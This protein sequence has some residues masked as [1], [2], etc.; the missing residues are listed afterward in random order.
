MWTGCAREGVHGW[1]VGWGV[2]IVALVLVS[3]RTAVPSDAEL[4]RKRT[5]DSLLALEERLWRAP[6]NAL[7]HQW[8]PQYRASWRRQVRYVI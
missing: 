4:A 5:R 8:T 3:R 1:L 7:M 2:I 6:N